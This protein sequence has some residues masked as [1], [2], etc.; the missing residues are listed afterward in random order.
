MR[1]RRCLLTARRADE[2]KYLR[3]FALMLPL[4]LSLA[5]AAH[6]SAQNPTESAH[7]RG[8]HGLEGWTLSRSLELR[9]TGDVYPYALIV[10]RDG[11]IIRRIDGSPFLWKWQ[12]WAGGKQIAYETGPLHFGLLCNLA[13][14]A[15]G[16]ER[17]SVDCYHELPADA[18]VWAAALE[19]QP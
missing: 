19:A 1:Y 13:D 4:S 3:R 5:I 11:K 16:K 9:S 17:A 14:L 6:L 10:A 15:T 18:P 8:P 12:F 7:R 2:V